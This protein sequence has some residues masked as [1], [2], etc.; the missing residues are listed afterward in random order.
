[1]RQRIWI[2]LLSDYDCEI[3]YHPGKANV[4]ADALSRKEREPIRVKALV[5]TVHPSLHDQIRNAQSEVMEKKN[6]KAE[7]LGRLIKPIFKIHPNGM[8]IK[9]YIDTKPNKELIHYCLQNP[10]YKFKWAKKTAPFAEGIDNDIYSTVNAFTNACEMWKAIERLKQEGK[11]LSI[12]LHPLMIKDTIV[13][14]EDDKMSNRA[15]QDNSPRINRGTGYDNQRIANVDGARENVDTAVNSGPIFDV[16]LLHEEQGDT[17]I[18][19]D[20]LDMSTNGETVDQDDD[21]LVN[22]RD[23]LASLIKKLK[24]SLKSQPKT[25]KIQFLNEIDRLSREYYYVDHMNAILGVYTTLDEFTDLQCDY[26]EQV[27]ECERLK[28]ELSTSKTMSK[29]FE[30]LQKH[31]IN[32]EIALQQCSHGTDLYSI[33]LQDTS[34]P[35]LICL[36]AKATSRNRTLVE[37]AQTILSAVKVP[38]YFWA[39]EISTS[40]FTQNR[41]LVIPRHEKTPYHIINGRKPSVKFFHIFG[42]LCYIVR[43]DEN[44]DKIKEKVVLK[45]SAVNAVDAPDKR[46]QQNTTQSTTTTIAADIPP[47]NIQITPVKTNQALTKATIITTTENIN[48]A[49][50]NTKN[51]QVEDDEFI[52]IFCTPVQERGE[53][54]SRHENK[55][56]EENTVIH[57]KAHLVAKGYA[58]KEGIDFKESFAPVAWLEA[59]RLFFAYATHKSFTVYQMDVKITFLYGTLKE[60]VYVNQP[61]GFVDPHHPDKVY[62]L[63]KVLYE[64]KQAPRAWYDELSNFLT[65]T[66]SNELVLLFNLVFDKLLNGTATVVLKTSAVNAVDAHDKRQQ[67]N[68]TQS[69]TTTIAADIPPLNIQ[70]T[71]ENKFDEENTVIHNKAHLVAKGYAQKEGIDFKESFAP[72]AWLEAVRLLFAYA[73]HKSFTVYQMDVK[74]TFLYGTLKEEVY[75]NQPDGF[76]DPHHPDKVCHLK[77]VLY[78][79]KQAPRAWYDELSNFLEHV[80]KGIVELFFVGTEYQLA[81]LFIKALPEDRFKYLVRRLGMRCLTLEELE[82]LEN[83]SA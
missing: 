51:A 55:C 36:M 2:E 58:Q 65:V 33:T 16:E 31:A 18:T 7:N 71:P 69:T 32:I 57:N 3:R 56:D 45:T 23:L 54:S 53:T 4:V 63:K 28:K 61:D 30:E 29:N 21:D 82:V 19:I 12:L 41:S 44:L 38:L 70:I 43:D 35:N 25:Q 9:R 59:V 8:R 26:L 48:Q 73:T 49:K 40:C 13:V 79:L 42:A 50:T 80:E 22:E 64:L 24:Y 72:V 10:P 76:V 14:T 34:T 77:N 27:V 78:E 11:Q 39:E 15:N 67:Q 60:E 37:A 1:M 74:T 52:N 81:D 75:V 17:N 62:H 83:K 6:V 5:M 46:Q 47:L 66:T 68:T 20:S